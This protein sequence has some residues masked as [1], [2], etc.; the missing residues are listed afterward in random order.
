MKEKGF[1]TETDLKVLS[2]NYEGDDNAEYVAKHRVKKKSENAIRDLILVAESPHVEI[3]SDI[4]YQRVTSLIHSLMMRQDEITPPKHFDGDLEEHYEKYHLQHALHDRL[5]RIVD[6]YD[7]TLHDE[8]EQEGLISKQE[9]EE[10]I[11]SVEERE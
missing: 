5:K 2:G 3:E 11:E 4:W 8:G 7:D 6:M 1:L 10:F 9:F